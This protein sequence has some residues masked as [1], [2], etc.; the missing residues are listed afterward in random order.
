MFAAAC[1][2]LKHLWSSFLET[3]FFSTLFFLLSC[4]PLVLLTFLVF[5]LYPFHLFIM[6]MVFPSSLLVFFL[7]FSIVFICLHAGRGRSNKATD[8]LASV[9]RRLTHVR[10]SVTCLFYFTLP[11]L[12]TAEYLKCDAVNTMR[13]LTLPPQIFRKPHHAAYTRL[14]SPPP[15]FLF[16]SGMPPNLRKPSRCGQRGS[17]APTTRSRR[18][19]RAPSVVQRPEGHQACD[20]IP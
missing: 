10:P 11:P 16:V 3:A 7:F 13:T 6:L 15:L 17:Q 18:R 12:A 20:A 14:P 5:F 8:A 2:Q 19:G 4:R 1:C 9:Q